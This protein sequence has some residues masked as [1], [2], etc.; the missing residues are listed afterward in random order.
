M[1][2]DGTHPMLFAESNCVCQ[3]FTHLAPFFFLVKYHIKKKKIEYKKGCGHK[4]MLMIFS[5][6]TDSKYIEVKMVSRD[7]VSAINAETRIL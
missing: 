5:G 2:P 1:W 6:D 3:S 7:D 4:Y